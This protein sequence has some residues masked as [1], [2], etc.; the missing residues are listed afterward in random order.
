MRRYTLLSAMLC[1][2]I[3]M[4]AQSLTNHLDVL[5]GDALLHTADASV[6]VYDLTADKMLYEHRADKLCRPASVE[7]VVTTVAA[8][9]RLGTDYTLHTE[10]RTTG[11]L[12][13]DSILHGDLYVVG[14][15]DPEF[16]A[17]DLNSLIAAIPRAGI[18][19]ISGSV[20]ADVSMADTTYWG[21]GWCW[22]DAP[23]AFQPYYSPLLLEKGCVEVCVTPT[24]RDS[25]AT[26]VCLPTS[27]WYEI[28]NRTCCYSDSDEPLHITRNW[29]DGSNRIIVSGNVEQ[30]HSR[31]LSVQT[32]DQHFFALFTE[33][34]LRSGIGA[35]HFGYGMCPPDARPIATVERSIGEVVHE[36]LKESDN[37]NA[38]AMLFH[39]AATSGKPYAKAS[40]GVIRID[41][42]L[43]S[44]HHTYGEKGTRV[45]PHKIVDGSGL[46]G[47]NMVSARLL[48]SV[49]RYAHSQPHIYDI[50]ADA[51]PHSGTDGT[52]KGR[53][54]NK[55]MRGRII[56]KTGSMTGVSTLAGYAHATNG[57]TLAFVIMNQHVL[58]LS[59]A[60]AWQDKV[61]TAI[62]TY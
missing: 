51:L 27:F 8:L 54:G 18:R 7:K 60:R 9:N 34:M 35:S 30:P 25:A 37:L 62:C 29:Q 56:A 44:I 40:D 11:F 12:D 41:S 57:H 22:D 26:I 48:L 15:F 59:Q 31:K 23:A 28:D 55:T 49:L 52:L 36:A 53:M 47:Y 50:L 39:L 19:S 20:L 42:L 33:R 6:V 2:S 1:G 46:S 21:S 45:P 5:L 61:C 38:E 17:D 43:V 24:V 10:L 14:G 13:T 32:S 3:L 16:T 4:M 58:K